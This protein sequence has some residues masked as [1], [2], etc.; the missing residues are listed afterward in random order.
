MPTPYDT[1]QDVLDAITAPVLNRVD[2]RNVN[3]RIGGAPHI[4]VVEFQLGDTDRH[5]VVCRHNLWPHESFVSGAAYSQVETLLSLRGTAVRFT[6]LSEIPEL[7]ET[8][9]ARRDQP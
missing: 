1:P 6:E 9:A 2:A 7:V 3:P 4:S 8:V 5:L